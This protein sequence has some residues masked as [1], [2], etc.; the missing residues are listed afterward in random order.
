MVRIQPK[1]QLILGEGDYVIQE[2][3]VEILLKAGLNRAD[4]L[5]ANTITDVGRI[6][7]SAKL[8]GIVL[9]SSI[10]ESSVARIIK[11]VR[12]N[13]SEIPIIVLTGDDA[14]DCAKAGA[15]KILQ[16]ERVSKDLVHALLEYGV[17]V[18]E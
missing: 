11:T 6:F 5:A 1:T 4:I 14:E 2:M 16:I 17:V 3:I 12:L 13:N 18:S 10:K 7:F 9:H 8:S 15:T